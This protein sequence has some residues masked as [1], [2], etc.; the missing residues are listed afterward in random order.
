[1]EPKAGGSR[2]DVHQMNKGGSG[3]TQGRIGVNGKGWVKAGGHGGKPMGLGHIQEVAE[4][5][6]AGGE[7]E[8]RCWSG[9]P[10]GPM[11]QRC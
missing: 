9:R 7:Q 3:M 10:A 5:R 1:V 2:G 6:T 4:T 8:V 11:G